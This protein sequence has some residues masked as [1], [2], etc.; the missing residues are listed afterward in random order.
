MRGAAERLLPGA[1]VYLETDFAFS[2]GLVDQF[3]HA[4]RRRSWSGD[5]GRSLT[6]A[7][8]LL[9]RQLWWCSGLLHATQAPMSR[10]AM[11]CR[12]RRQP[13]LQVSILSFGNRQ[14]AIVSGKESLTV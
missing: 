2:G 9:G 11:T 5:R 10:A 8:L 14:N 4:G 12:L 6:I 13:R 3:S 7:G 1:T